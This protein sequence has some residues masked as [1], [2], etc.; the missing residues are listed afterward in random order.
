MHRT[1][2]FTIIELIVAIAVLAILLTIGVPSIQQ[3]IKNNRVTAQTNELVSVINFARNESIRR[4]QSVDMDL[5]SNAS[6]WSAEVR[7]PDGAEDS[8]GCT[9]GVLR[10]ADYNGVLL[11]SGTD[12]F[13]FNNRGYVDGFTQVD[14]VLQHTDC[15]GDRQ[16]REITILPTGQVSSTDAACVE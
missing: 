13:A 2:G 3:L 15:S 1:G 11:P 8:E 14:I 6:G 7:S 16:R 9:V 10:C 12:S 5:I 4:N